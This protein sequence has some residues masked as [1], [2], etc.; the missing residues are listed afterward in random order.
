MQAKLASKYGTGEIAKEATLPLQHIAQALVNLGLLLADK[1]NHEQSMEHAE[2]GNLVQRAEEAEDMASTE[3]G[4]R[5]KASAELAAIRAGAGLAKIAFGT[6]LLGGLADAAKGAVGA[7]GKALSPGWKAK[8]LIGAGTIGAGVAA[9][10]GMQGARNYMSE[11][12][13]EAQH[14]GS[15]RPVMHNVSEYGAPVFGS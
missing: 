8:A 15:N 4:L 9:Y 14:W 11:P 7:V 5:K 2:E 1:A 3:A 6:P 13:H 12:G 10:K